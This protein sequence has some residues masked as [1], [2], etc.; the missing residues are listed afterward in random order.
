MSPRS[1]ICI[2]YRRNDIR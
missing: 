1:M 2:D